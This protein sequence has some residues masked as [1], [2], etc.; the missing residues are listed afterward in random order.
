MKR[1]C[2]FGTHHRHYQ[3]VKV[4]RWCR[5]APPP[6]RYSAPPFPRQTLVAMKQTDACGE[7]PGYLKFQP[8]LSWF[9]LHSLSL[10]VFNVVCPYCGACREAWRSSVSV[11][12]VLRREGTSG[13]EEALNYFWATIVD[14]SWW[15]D[16]WS[17]REKELSV[18]FELLILIVHG[19]FVVWRSSCSVFSRREGA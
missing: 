3:H 1:W 7:R 9:T 11:V 4:T 15:G 14:G 12:M 18:S 19:G 10:Q 2:I 8:L 16:G 13:F 17:S 6:S 5:W